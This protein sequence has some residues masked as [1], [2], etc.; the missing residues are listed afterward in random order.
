MPNRRAHESDAI[1]E[2]SLHRLVALAQPTP[3]FIFRAADQTLIFANPRFARVMGA[4]S[5]EALIGV[6]IDRLFEF[7]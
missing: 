1:R 5:P 6:S 2:Q 7:G 3:V 4:E